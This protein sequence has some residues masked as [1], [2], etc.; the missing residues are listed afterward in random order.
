MALASLDRINMSLLLN[1]SSY[2]SNKLLHKANKRL[3][4]GGGRYPVEVASIG[5]LCLLGEWGRCSHDVNRI[6]REF[7]S[8]WTDGAEKGRDYWRRPHCQIA[9]EKSIGHFK[10]SG[11][12][13]S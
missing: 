9:C 10:E 7:V 1:K 4:F 11:L 5:C 12:K 6:P 8:H 2:H 13:R 3:W